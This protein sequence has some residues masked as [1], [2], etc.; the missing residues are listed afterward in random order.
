MLHNHTL[1]WN[2]NLQLDINVYTFIRCCFIWK[3]A[4]TKTFRLNIVV[5]AVTSWLLLTFTMKLQAFTNS[6]FAA[7][8]W[9]L[10]S[11]IT[12]VTLPTGI[13]FTI[14]AHNFDIFRAIRYGNNDVL[15]VSGWRNV[16]VFTYYNCTW[17]NKSL[18]ENNNILN[19][20]WMTNVNNALYWV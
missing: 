7:V 2:D 14:F 17:N 13:Y 6:S 1:C 9:L 4:S 19:K 15:P 16:M 20:M 3:E 11:I 18:D 10:W 12:N 5:S 8:S